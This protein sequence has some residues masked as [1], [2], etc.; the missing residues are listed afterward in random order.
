M[1]EI[2][3][4]YSKLGLKVGLEIHQQLNTKNKL[5]CNCPTELTDEPGEEFSR[6][7]RPTRSETGEVD[8]AA[9]F[10]WRKNKTYKYEAPHNHYCLVESDEE[11]PHEIN[12]EAIVIASS[13]ALALNSD[14]VGEV[15]T[16]RKIVIDGSNTSGF[17]R[18]AIVALN[19]FI[20]VKGKRY[21]IETIAVEEDAARKIKETGSIITYRLDR[22][23][24]PLIEI[25][26][27]PDIHDPQEA[28]EVALAIGRLLRLTGKVKRGLGTIRQDLNVSIIG[29][30]KTEIKGVQKLDLIEKIISYEALRQLNLLKLKDELNKRGLIKDNFDNIHAIDLTNIFTNTKSKIIK[31]KIENGGKVLGIKLEKM[32][33]LIGFELMPNRRFG[34]ELAD[35]ARF[36]AGIEGLFHSDELPNYG[37]TEQ[38]V[39]KAY[40]LL[41]ADRES[42]A[43]IIIADEEEKCKKAI[44]TIIDRVKLAFDGVPEETRGANEDGTTKYL[45]P[46]PGKERMYPETDI[47]PLY[48][49]YD[50]IKEAEKLKPEP[51]EK[52]LKIFIEK[53]NFSQELADKV[54]NDINLG[55]IEELINKYGNRV[56]PSFIASLFV[57]IFKGLKSKGIDV[58][59]LDEN[60]IEDIVK[61]LAEGKIA[62]EAIEEII[63]K[64]TNQVEKS[65]DDIVNEMGI[66]TISIDEAKEIIDDI[67]NSNKDLILAKGD[68]AMSILMGRAMEK[69]RGKIDGKTVS[70][71]LKSRIE[72]IL[73]NSRK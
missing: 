16:M 65:I 13:V 18:T 39:E 24:I 60:K 23:G 22:L 6:K 59:S 25:S 8:I 32:K 48:I 7:L 72:N 56:Q 26:T 44:S 37:I 33:G 55:F 28:K 57:S 29:G 50:I 64:A 35:Y 67:V 62:K 11:P 5:F 15:H 1:D 63:E 49:N 38:E 73:N 34:T 69:L 68:R 70:E 20:G 2:N 71:L 43:F 46:R 66:K 61:L 19:G 17:Q 45:R 10:E 4:D 9:L 31:N 36:Y 52:K 30:A 40:N 41:Q 47:K 42:D 27:S 53:Y 58:D 54:I 51:V 14:L 3:I 21:G 12:K